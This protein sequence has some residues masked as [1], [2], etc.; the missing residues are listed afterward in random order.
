MVLEP[1]SGRL[2]SLFEEV[3]EA[4]QGEGRKQG[5]V[6]YLG[7]KLL[8]GVKRTGRFFKFIVVS[9]FCLG[10]GSLEL[11]PR[12]EKDWQTGEEL[13]EPQRTPQQD[14]KIFLL[15]VLKSRSRNTELSLD[16][17]GPLLTTRDRE[18]TKRCLPF[19]GLP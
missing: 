4:F 15:V 8:L 12:G 14:P 5:S 16:L 18:E 1:C 7:I 10:E 3:I 11:R 17:A 9:S 2:S 6:T 13:G 19:W